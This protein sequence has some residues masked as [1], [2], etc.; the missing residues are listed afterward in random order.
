MLTKYPSC[1]I[2]KDAVDW[3]L[4]NVTELK[5]REDAIELGNLLMS[6]G[7]FRHVTREHAFKDQELFYAFEENFGK[8]IFLK[9]KIFQTITHPKVL[10]K[11]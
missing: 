4:K 8:D 10:E 6:L 3:L 11:E 2:G 1:F 7:L 9:K 5:T